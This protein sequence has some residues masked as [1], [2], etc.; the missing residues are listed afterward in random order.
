MGKKRRDKRPFGAYEDR[1]RILAEMGYAS[2][3]AY[4]ESDLWKSIRARVIGTR[5]MA[6]RMCGKP[7]TAVHHNQYSEANL[8]G[9]SLGHLFPIC[10]SCHE[11]VEFVNGEKAEPRRVFQKFSEE[12][13]RFNQ[14][15]IE[16][17]KPVRPK[18]AV[19]IEPTK[20]LPFE[21]CPIKSDGTFALITLDLVMDIRSE[22]GGWNRHQ[23]RALGVGWPP[24]GGW[25]EQ[26]KGAGKT[27]L[28]R[29]WEIAVANKR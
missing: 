21:F 17:G 4:L 5:G 25:T 24:R 18:G 23:L 19:Y 28:L 20:P 15:L 11:S 2:Y 9:K 26:F 12:M 29:D 6:C 1:D 8:T 3:A 13:S 10:H 7:A 22:R 27:I 14:R 16:Q